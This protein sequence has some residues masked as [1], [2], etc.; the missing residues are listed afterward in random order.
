MSV[1]LIYGP[2]ELPGYPARKESINFATGMWG[3]RM[4]V[5]MQFI[6]GV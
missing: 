3:I 4:P 2:Q 1:S 6:T 5:F